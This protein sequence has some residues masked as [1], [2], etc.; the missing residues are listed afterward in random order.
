MG[1]STFMQIFL[2]IDV[3]IMGALAAVAARHGYAH[4]H[5]PEHE[6]EHHGHPMQNGHLP[7]AVREKILQQSEAHFQTV[8]DRSADQ[9]QH[10]LTSTAERLN[11]LLEKLGTEIVGKEMERYRLELDEIHKQADAAMSGAQTEIDTHQT[12]LKAKLAEEIAAEKQQLVAQID[13]RLNDAV[14]SFLVETLGHNVD[15]G[16]QNQY[17]MDL[18]D[19]HKEA[20]KKEV[21]DETPAA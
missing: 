12:E 8:L 20:F 11:K 14:A 9:L 5:P 6:P 2:I 21:D 16:A 15:L 19:Q 18:L 1:G 17:L 7:P 10:D 4:F 3:F 13:T